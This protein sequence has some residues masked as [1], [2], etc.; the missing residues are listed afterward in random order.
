MP[1]INQLLLDDCEK[2]FATGD[3]GSLL[4]AIWCCAKD[5]QPLPEWASKAFITAYESGVAGE[6]K[7]WDDVFGKPYP[8]GSNLNAIKKRMEKRGALANRIRQLKIDDPSIAIDE[9][10]FERVGA[11]FGVGKTLASE[12]YY[13]VK[14]WMEKNG[15]W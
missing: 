12:F 7:S 2:R 3:L 8:K 15:V 1:Y 10:L 9:T 5:K 4:I 11:E 14:N 6:A 13:E